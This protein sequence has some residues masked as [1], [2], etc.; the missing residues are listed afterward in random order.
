[1]RKPKKPPPDTVGNVRGR[2][3]AL[4][5]TARQG[6]SMDAR[7]GVDKM[8]ALGRHMKAI[9][10]DLKKLQRRLEKARKLE[11]SAPAAK[12]ADA[13]GEEKKTREAANDATPDRDEDDLLAKLD[14][15]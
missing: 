6:A 9:E 13:A 7:E 5:T 15:L 14:S 1:M 4:R 10:P 3:G 8:R 2:I 11:G 12:G